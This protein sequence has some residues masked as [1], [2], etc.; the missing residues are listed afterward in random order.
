MKIINGPIEVAG[1]PSKTEHSAELAV[2]FEQD[3]GVSDTP[4]CNTPREVPRSF[5]TFY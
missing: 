1:K 3:E 4:G 2:P 5:A